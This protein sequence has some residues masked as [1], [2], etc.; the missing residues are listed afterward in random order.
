MSGLSSSADDSPVLVVVINDP[1]DLARAREEGWYRIPLDRAPRR[2]AADYLAFYQTAAFP[3]TERWAVRWFAPVRGYRIAS[4][5]E[6]IPTEPAH[7]RADALYYK[8]MLGALE[9]L[10]RPVPSR[11]L[12]R[13]TF[14]PTTLAR[15]LQAQE[16]NDL[17]I[18]SSAQERLWAALK[19]AD[20]ETE[21]QYPLQND[22]PQYVADFAL[23]CRDGR[24]AVLVTDE[25][26][27]AD[28]LREASPADYLLAANAWRVVRVTRAE[29]ETAAAAWA[30]H[31]ARL[32]SQLGGPNRPTPDVQ[33]I[34]H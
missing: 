20:L 1:A 5:R 7:P 9:P 22:L 18:K 28:E 32:V 25:P 12:R 13:I 26:P 4:R 27:A 6:L 33:L 31:L 29:L 8:V 24:I 16:I 23:F 19:Q 30:A 10:P 14:I 17:W 34:L 2:I 15:L 21:R 11:R 3:A